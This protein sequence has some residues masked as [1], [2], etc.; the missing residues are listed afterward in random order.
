MKTSKQRNHPKCSSFLPCYILHYVLTTFLCSSLSTALPCLPG[1][2]YQKDEREYPE[3]FHSS[4][5]SVTVTI[6]P[7]TT[8]RTPC[9][10]KGLPCL[11]WLVA[12]FSGRRRQFHARSFKVQFVVDNLVVFRMFLIKRVYLTT[13]TRYRVRRNKDNAVTNHIWVAIKS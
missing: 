11:K 8:H 13:I 1:Y 10:F 4:S 5:Y 7:L 12:G 9:D 2:R 3:K 6:S